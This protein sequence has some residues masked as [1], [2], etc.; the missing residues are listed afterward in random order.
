MIL[1]WASI[2]AGLGCGYL[3]CV[4][5]LTDRFTR[6]A[7]CV[8]QPCWPGVT[9]LKALHGAEPSETSRRSVGKPTR[10]PCKSSSAFRTRAMT[11]WQWFSGFG[12][13]NM[14]R[15][16][17]HDNADDPSPEPNAVKFNRCRPALRPMTS[18]V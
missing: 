5:L 11:R 17:D 14:W 10:A 15:K 18:H 7:S 13:K 8:E 12:R 4:R 1:C 9:I 2:I 16:P 6:E 3:I